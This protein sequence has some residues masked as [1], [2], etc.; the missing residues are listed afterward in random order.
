MRSE[1]WIIKFLLDWPLCICSDQSAVMY[2]EWI[3]PQTSMR[4][5]AGS[6]PALLK[7]RHAQKTMPYYQP[8][9]AKSIPYYDEN[10]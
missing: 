7:T 6:N 8:K 2:P 4:G 10:G 9:W 3:S 1:K 5:N